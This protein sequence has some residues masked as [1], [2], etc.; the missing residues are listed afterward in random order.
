VILLGAFMLATHPYCRF[1]SEGEQI[2]HPTLDSP[3][4]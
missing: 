1:T 3:I 2:L 4:G